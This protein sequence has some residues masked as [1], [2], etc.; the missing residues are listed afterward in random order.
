MILWR[1]FIFSQV[2]TNSLPPGSNSTWYLL[3][4]NSCNSS[5]TFL[6]NSTLPWYVTINNS[7]HCVWRICF[8][9]MDQMHD[10]ALWTSFLFKHGSW[11]VFFT[12]LSFCSCKM[13]SQTVE[14]KTLTNKLFIILF[15]SS[16]S[17]SL[18]SLPSTVYITSFSVFS[19]GKTLLFYNP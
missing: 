3:L 9:S 10:K 13:T 4:S 15:Y 1:T 14:E 19:F 7:M 2:E 6:S 8:L 16:I 11:C 5:I 17:F 18:F 12:C